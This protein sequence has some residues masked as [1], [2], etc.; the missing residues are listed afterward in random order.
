MKN[1]LISVALDPARSY[2]DGNLCKWL[3][4]HYSYQRGESK[5]KSKSFNRG[6]FFTYSCIFLLTV[7]LL[8]LQSLEERLRHFPTKQKSSNCK[9]KPQIVIRK[10]PKHN[11][12]QK[13]SAVSRKL[14]IV[15]KKA[16]SKQHQHK[17]VDLNRTHP[18]LTLGLLPWPVSIKNPSVW[19]LPFERKTL[20]AWLI[21]LRWH[22]CRAKSA[23]M[24]SFELQIFLRKMLRSF[25]PI[26]LSLYFVDRKKSRQIPAKFPT[27]FPCQKFK[28]ITDE[29]LQEHRGNRLFCNLSGKRSR[30]KPKKIPGTPAGRVPGI[31][32]GTNRC[33]PASV[34]EISCCLFTLQNCVRL[35]EKGNFAGHRLLGTPGCPPGFQKFYVICFCA[36]CAPNDCFR[37][38]R[39]AWIGSWINCKYYLGGTCKTHQTFWQSRPKRAE[40]RAQKWELGSLLWFASGLQ[41]TTQRITENISKGGKELN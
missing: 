34:P 26:F 20:L 31:P 17:T 37:Q 7:E 28:K 39:L 18:G 33:L 32:G 15:S 25:P 19:R 24:I 41:E 40:D 11:C 27:K 9:Q 23:R 5:C 8:C 29:H 4:S 36:F 1:S 30:H 13:S 3:T 10:A 12:T 16:A 2:P 14:P 21:L 22:V 6:S 38:S 35:T